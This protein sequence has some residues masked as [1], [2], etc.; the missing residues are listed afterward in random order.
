MEQENPDVF[1]DLIYANSK[2]LREERGAPPPNI[3]FE[4]LASKMIDVTENG[5]VKKQVGYFLFL[6]C[7]NKISFVF[8]FFFN[9]LFN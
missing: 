4:L 7:N 1:N 3:S 6:I 2:H 5:Y 9:I 8:F